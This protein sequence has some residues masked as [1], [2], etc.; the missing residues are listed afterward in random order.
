MA[1]CDCHGCSHPA[2]F[3]PVIVIELPPI[4]AG[5]APSCA[6]AK[7]EKNVCHIHRLVMTVADFLSLEGWRDLARGFKR[8]GFIVPDRERVAL[9]WESVHEVTAP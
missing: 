1:A 6:R 7:L 9:E 2:A 3:R 4:H 5:R 8:A